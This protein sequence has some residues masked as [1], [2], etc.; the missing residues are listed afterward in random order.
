MTAS[1][2]D[3]SEALKAT[4]SFWK[5]LYCHILRYLRVFAYLTTLSVIAYMASPPA[6][7]QPTR[8]GTMELQHRIVMAPMSRYRA[9]EEHVP[10]KL[11][12]EYYTQRAHSPGS[13]I[14][15]E[16]TYID[17]R[18]GGQRKAP[19]IWSV[20]Q[21][22]AWKEIV[23]RVHEK[24]SFMYLQLWAL[25]RSAYPE[26][27][28]EKG[29][30]YVSA[31]AI[32]L[33]QRDA[34]PR[35]LTITEIKEYVQLYAKAAANAVHGAGF[36]GVEIHGANGYLVDQ[37][38]QSVSN[39]RTDEYG[40]GIENRMRFALEV[41]DAVVGAVGANKTALRLSPWG[42]FQ[43]MGMSDPIPT[44]S[45]L[46]SRIK[47]KHSDLAY[48]HVVEPDIE[49]QEVGNA[50]QSNAFIRDIWLPRPLICA[51]GFELQTA[52]EAAETKGLLVGFARKYLSNPDL[53]LRLKKDLPLNALD[54]PT[55]YTG[56]ARG[57][58][59]YPFAP[60]DS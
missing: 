60:D 24:G 7:F 19:G 46:V 27:L 40:G 38:L 57:Y 17:E 45:A 10:G 51:N 28:A 52:I 53:V 43:D 30:P 48:I 13:L 6:L 37:F 44:F 26:V 34:T 1:L 23:D 55:F 12:E 25:G 4:A 49:G 32:K 20:E 2:S 35:P 8:V 29:H 58:I 39:E 11:A 59:D 15:T 5:S 56:G 47:G 22:A 18:A 36:D 50:V 3:G 14:I 33:S 9:S 31:S 41:L 16:G 54:Y 42:T 21:I